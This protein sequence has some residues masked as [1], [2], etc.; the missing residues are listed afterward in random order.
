MKT[1][2][3]FSM[4]VALSAVQAQELLEL[5]NEIKAL[6]EEIKERPKREEIINVLDLELCDYATKDDIKALNTALNEYATKDYIKEAFDISLCA[7]KA[8]DAKASFDYERICQSSKLVNMADLGWVSLAKEKTTWEGA[9][10]S[11]LANGGRLIEGLKKN[12]FL[13]LLDNLGGDG[14]DE[15][16]HVGIYNETWL[17]SGEKVD[18]DLYHADQPSRGSNEV[19]GYMHLSKSCH[20]LGD[21]SCEAKKYFLCQY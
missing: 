17:S 21:D 9:R 5:S 13:S 1:L 7:Y 14:Y 12:H 3:V 15:Y 2:L 4:F 18:L 10:N 19:C 6:R 20:G 8:K 16:F 11:C